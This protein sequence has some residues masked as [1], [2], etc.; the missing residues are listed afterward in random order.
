MCRR[1]II[2]ALLSTG[3]TALVGAP[4]MG[5]VCASAAQSAPV[6]EAW[7]KEFEDI[8]S[9]TQDAMTF[10]REELAA[11]ISR[12]DALQPQ[13]EKLDETRKKVYLGRLRMCRGLYQYVL[14]SKRGTDEHSASKAQSAPAQEAWQKEFDDVCSKTQDAM[15]FSQ[16]ELASLISRCDALQPQIEKLDETRKKVYL[17][18]LRMCRGFYANV[19]DA[20]KNEKK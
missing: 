19:L 9:K 16:E 12:C 7:Q 4:V 8:C 10:S 20:K 18:R 6:Q 17:G 1:M 14:D 3:L 15:T 5:E 13:I 2:V 11:L